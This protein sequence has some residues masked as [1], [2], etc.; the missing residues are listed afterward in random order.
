MLSTKHSSIVFFVRIKSDNSPV[1][2]ASTQE[3]YSSG[4]RQQRGGHGI[5][6]L[7]SHHD[8]ASRTRAADDQ[9]ETGAFLS[10][11]AA[12]ASRVILLLLDVCH[13]NVVCL[14]SVRCPAQSKQH[15]L[16]SSP[17]SLTP[18]EPSL[19]AVMRQSDPTSTARLRK[20]EGEEEE[21]R[22]ITQPIEVEAE[23]PVDGEDSPF[24]NS[25]AGSKSADD[26]PDLNT[27]PEG[28]EDG[29]AFTNK[30]IE[31]D[32]SVLE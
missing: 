20:N 5:Q 31:G 28:E 2:A 25:S 16:H 18:A 15:C 6:G 9:T 24:S 23:L 1:P 26:Y 32:P 30:G 27:N 11:T 22:S 29:F 10:G 14:L 7:G 19:Q 3:P 17:L 21:A 4:G 12:A 13:E 8:H